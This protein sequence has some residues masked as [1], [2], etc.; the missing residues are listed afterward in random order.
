MYT[1]CSITLSHH[2][3]PRQAFTGSFTNSILG[4]NF[5]S[6]V[7][8]LIFRIFKYTFSHIFKYFDLVRYSKNMSTIAICLKILCFLWICL[9]FFKYQNYSF[10]LLEAKMVGWIYLMHHPWNWSLIDTVWKS[11]SAMYKT[12]AGYWF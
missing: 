9:Y 6:F 8:I 4:A 11:S 5:S 7:R 2:I 1:L 3:L 12:D 10:V